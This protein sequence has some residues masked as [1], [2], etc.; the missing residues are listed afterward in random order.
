MS[1]NCSS[2]DSFYNWMDE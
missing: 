1:Y 2:L